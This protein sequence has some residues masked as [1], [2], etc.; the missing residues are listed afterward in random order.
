MTSLSTSLDTWC[1]QVVPLQFMAQ[2][3]GLQ[4]PTV[5]VISS[6]I[7]WCHL[8]VYQLVSSHGVSV[9]VIS[10]C[11]SW[12]HLMV[13]QLVSSH[14]VSVG[15][16]MYQLVSWCISWCHDVS[17]P[18]LMSCIVITISI[19]SSL[20]LSFDLVRLYLVLLDPQW[21]WSQSWSFVFD[22]GFR[23]ICSFVCYLKTLAFHF[24]VWLIHKVLLP[25]TA[26]IGT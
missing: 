5:G 6:C 23:S 4:C 2:L 21:T 20:V 16:M 12:C 3:V 14:H 1:G 17:I 11:I 9:G 24:I 22:V 15:V 26:H 19:V 8:M 10:W 13:Y 7:S 25:A 18:L